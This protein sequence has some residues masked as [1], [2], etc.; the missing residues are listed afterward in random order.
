M[1]LDQ[2]TTSLFPKLRKRQGFS[3]KKASRIHGERVRSRTQTG[4]GAAKRTWTAIFTGTRIFPPSPPTFSGIG[5]L[6]YPGKAP[7]EAF[8]RE[9]NS[10]RSKKQSLRSPALPGYISPS[11]GSGKKI[12][13]LDCGGGEALPLRTHLSLSLLLLGPFSARNSLRRPC[14]SSIDAVHLL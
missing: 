7:T 4:Q 6:I 10:K 5:A 1:D 2:P 11:G 3:R 13:T 12:E 14:L 9:T 8:W